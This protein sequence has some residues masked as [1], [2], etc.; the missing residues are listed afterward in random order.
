M[1]EGE[2]YNVPSQSG[3][4]L[5]T[6]NAGALDIL[7]DGQVIAPIG[8]VGAVRRDVLLEPTALLARGNAR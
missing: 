5:A 6:G 3:I 7:V 1:K 4:T 8:P 2:T